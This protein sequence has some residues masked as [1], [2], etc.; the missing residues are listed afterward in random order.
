MTKL[1][2]SII[3]ESFVLDLSPNY[4]IINFVCVIAEK[5]INYWDEI[6]NHEH[7]ISVYRGSLCLHND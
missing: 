5:G 3:L 4:V 6:V 1:K 7:Y 2:E